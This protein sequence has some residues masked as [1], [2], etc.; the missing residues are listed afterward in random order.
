M[1]RDSS[2]AIF[3]SAL[4]RFVSLTHSTE[5]AP[6]RSDSSGLGMPGMAM[7]PAWLSW[8]TFSSS[9]I[10]ARSLST[11]AATWASLGGAGAV[12][13]AAAEAASSR[14]GRNEVLALRRMAP[15]IVEAG[16]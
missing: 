3:C 12:W 10:C 9:V 1:S 13:A 4:K 2:T 7:P 15:P 5:P 8:P 16:S 11:R 6:W 14:A